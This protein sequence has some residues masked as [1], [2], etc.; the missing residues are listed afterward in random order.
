MRAFLF[1]FLLVFSGL[2]ARVT[3]GM[4]RLLT[5]SCYAPLLKD[6]RI[7]L[8]S[9][10]TA[11]CKGQKLAA[12]KILLSSYTLTAIFAPEHGFLGNYH[13]EERVKEELYAGKIPIHSLHGQT[14]R[15]TKA[16]FENIDILIFDIQDIGCR[17]YTYISTLF[18][19]MEEAARY[20]IP[21]I[22]TDRPNPIGGLVVDGPALEEKYRSFIG[23]INIPYC[24]GMTAGELALYFNT[25]YK[26][27]CDL[28]VIPMKGWKRSMHFADTGLTWVPTSPHI[29]ECDSPLFY[30][31]CGVVG[32]I[33]LVS[34][35]VGYT[36]PFKVIGAPWMD[37]EVF[38]KHLNKQGFPGVTFLPCYFKPFYGFFKNQDCAGVQIVVTNPNKIMP[39]QTQFLIIGMLKSLYPEAFKKAFATVKKESFCKVA[40]TDEVYNILKNEQYAIYKLKSLC[41]CNRKI[42]LQKRSG[43]LLKDYSLEK[44]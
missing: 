9:N 31:I 8:I 3:V 15:P 28:T 10:H 14:R 22:V 43:Y 12:E 38:A 19:V 34:T 42:F 23:Y 37:G 1:V 11:L 36:T 4:D 25:E 13:A 39:V 40:G 44:R 7:G 27:G 16:M 41:Q 30:T 24:H 26:V 21:V 35:G 5:E 18:Y 2:Q 17:S 6:K 32:E 33:S 29:P 20:K